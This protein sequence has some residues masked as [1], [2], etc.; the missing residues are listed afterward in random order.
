MKKKELDDKNK[1]LSKKKSKD[2]FF[3]KMF[4]SKKR[5]DDNLML[6]ETDLIKDQVEVKFDWSKNLKMF[7]IFFAL[8]LII[9][10]EAY[11]L[12]FWWGNRKVDE[13][14]YYLEKEINLLS[15]EIEA[16]DS[17]YKE[18]ES[19]KEKI[20]LSLS[21]LNDHIYWS[22]FFSLLEERTLKKHVY[23]ENFSGDIS[24]RYVLPAVTDDVRAIN[25]QSR[26]LLL[27]PMVSRALIDEEEIV[28]DTSENRRF[29]KFNINLNLNTN[30]FKKR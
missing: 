20:N 26:Y 24:G 11:L 12:L 27:D 28:S 19:F 22:N 3:K 2:N 16:L 29:F 4:Q 9:V 30:I 10:L 6:L 23:Y 25:F 13:S 18:A 5:T 7:L 1:K 14:S 8:A 21:F 17:D 15:S